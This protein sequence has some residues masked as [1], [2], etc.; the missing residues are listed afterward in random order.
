MIPL[1]RLNKLRPESIREYLKKNGRKLVY[2]YS[3]EHGAYWRPDRKGYTFHEEAAGIYTLQDAYEA[4][5]HCDE[6]K[7]IWYMPAEKQRILPKY[8]EDGVKAEPIRP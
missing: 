3:Y 8:T 7:K 4:T 1:F 2:I 5:G 6:S